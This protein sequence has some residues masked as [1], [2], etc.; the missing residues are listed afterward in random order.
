MELMEQMGSCSIRVID[1]DDGSVRTISWDPNVPD[2]V[3]ESLV[4]SQLRAQFGVS[5]EAWVDLIDTAN[6]SL[7]H[8]TKDVLSNVKDSLCL[9]LSPKTEALAPMKTNEVFEVMFEDRSLGM[10]IREHNESVIVNHFKRKPDGSLGQAEACGRIQSDDVIYKVNGARTVGRSYDNVVQMLQTQTRPL[11]IQF[12]RPFR[13]D[14]LF[15]VEFRVKDL[16]MAHPNIVGYAEAHGVRIF[17]II[18]A[19]DGE[20]INGLEYNRAISLLS[21]PTRPIVVVFARSKIM[22]PT[23]GRSTGV[24]TNRFSFASTVA[25]SPRP[26]SMDGFGSRRGSGASAMSNVDG[27]NMMVEEMLEFCEGLGNDGLLNP[28]E[29]EMLKDMVLTMRPDVCSAVKRRNN[30]AIVAIVR[31]PFMRLWDS[32]LKTRESILLAGPVSLK[33]KKRFHLLLTDHERL[34]FV[35]KDTNLL[36]DEIMCSQIVTVSSRS[37]YQELTISTNKMDYVLIDNFIG[38]VIWVRAILPFT[39]TQGVLKVASSRRFLGSKKRYFVLRGN[40]LTGYKKESM[41]HQVGAKSS[42]I[43]LSDATINVSDP[44]GL[45]FV[46]TTPEFDQAGKKLILT[47]T[48]SREFNKWVTALNGLQTASPTTAA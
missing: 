16:P 6:S 18:H 33:R 46:I 14:G 5:D 3:F 24:M 34:L 42:T 7:V 20:V 27:E 12:F 1:L 35:N 22:P 8:I 39:C 41:I 44:R 45:S 26:S 30:N 10:T 47:A 48:S 11:S 19:V 40:S 29:V 17:D 36:E 15:A 23:P 43:S 32:L 4:E 13:R 9:C 38:P 28:K 31:S 37:K 21:R 2:Q 25:P